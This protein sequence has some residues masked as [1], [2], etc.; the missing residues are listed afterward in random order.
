MKIARLFFIIWLLLDACVDPFT[1]KSSGAGEQL[2]VDGMITD[3]PGPYTI[4]LYTT[5]SLDTQLDQVNWVKGAKVSITDDAG[6]T[7]NLTETSSGNYQTGGIQ[8]QVGRT[9]TLHITTAEGHVYTSAAETLLPVGEINDLYYTFNQ[10]EDP[11]QTDY[12]NTKNAFE[13][14]IDAGVLPEQEGRVRWRTTGTFEIKTSPE[15]KTRTEGAKGGGIVIIPD[16][17]KC[18]GWTYDAKNGLKQVGECTCCECWVTLYSNTPLLSDKT[19]VVNNAI[20]KYKLGDVTASRRFFYKKYYL[21]VD[22]MSMSETV[23]NFWERVATQKQSGS[24]LFQTPPGAT[25]GNITSE[26]AG[27]LPA[28]GVFAASSIRTRSIVIDRSAVPYVLPDIDVI[29]ESCASPAVY[30]NSTT[31][32][33]PFW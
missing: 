29:T 19:F 2:V 13:I 20:D 18:S 31:T 21:T 16:P 17:P 6:N 23:Y 32:K 27:A 4:M 11:T 30:V 8:G 12:L 24:D 22:Q 7:E 9:Y 25:G 5:K 14:F 3:Q 15:A 1:I 10:A 26:S 28:L 33:P